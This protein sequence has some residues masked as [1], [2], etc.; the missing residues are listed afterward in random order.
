MKGVLGRKILVL[1]H[2]FVNT[3]SERYVG[4]S[5]NIHTANYASQSL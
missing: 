3:T 5:C 1:R 2:G 4:D